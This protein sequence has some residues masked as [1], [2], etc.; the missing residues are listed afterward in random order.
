MESICLMKSTECFWWRTP[1]HGEY[2]AISHS[3]LP[4]ESPYN[5]PKAGTA[6]R[7]SYWPF[8]G[9]DP[10]NLPSPCFMSPRFSVQ[11]CHSP[12]GRPLPPGHCL[13]PCVWLHWPL[14]VLHDVLSLAASPPPVPSCLHWVTR[15]FS[16][17]TNT[18]RGSQASAVSRVP[19][20]RGRTQGLPGWRPGADGRKMWPVSHREVEA[21]SGHHLGTQARSC[22]LDTFL[23]MSPTPENSPKAVMYFTILSFPAPS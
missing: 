14:S 11:P 15:P 10:T 7:A 16:P 17:T 9:L 19:G 3:R 13:A 8:P 21:P 1:A 23:D 6:H 4:Q 18:T 12:L 5:P 20:G 22:S 2:L